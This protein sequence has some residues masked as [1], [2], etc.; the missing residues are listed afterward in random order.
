M[1]LNIDSP[2]NKAEEQSEKLIPETVGLVFRPSKA[3]SQYVFDTLR[4][5][6]DQGVKIILVGDHPLSA[7]HRLSLGIDDEWSW[8]DVSKSSLD[9]IIAFG[10]DG[11][12]L[13]SLN[14]LGYPSNSFF[15]GL[16]YGNLGFLTE[17]SNDEGTTL[18]KSIFDG[19]YWVDRRFLLD[20]VLWRGDEQIWQG[21]SLNELLL[22]QERMAR[23][24]KVS[25]FLDKVEMA[26]IQAD[27]F[28]IATPTGST[29]YALSAGGPIL[30]PFLNCFE[31]TPVASHS[32][33]S[34][35]IVVHDR[36]VASLVVDSAWHSAR[37]Y[38]DGIGKCDLQTGDKVSVSASQKKVSFIRVKKHHYYKT[39]RDKLN[40]NL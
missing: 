5:L 8:E 1:L 10:G 38:V 15:L 28:I 12:L 17:G 37:I 6:K 7:E 11:T 21:Y 32:M 33:N 29:A 24:L 35:S 2:E 25:L 4:F 39:L 26:S 22:R 30:H 3:L 40:W 16:N 14:E 13:H 27:G 20:I 19:D 36:G 18:L 34:R 31:I 23:P 9:L